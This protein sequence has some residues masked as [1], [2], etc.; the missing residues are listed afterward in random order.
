AGARVLISVD[1]P[2]LVNGRGAS[3]PQPGR[4]HSDRLPPAPTTGSPWARI[5]GGPGA[6]PPP[7]AHRRPVVRPGRGRSDRP[8][9]ADL[10]AA[11]QLGG[12]GCRSHHPR[13]VGAVTEWVRW[14][15]LEGQKGRRVTRAR[16]FLPFLGDVRIGTTLQQPP[17]HPLRYRSVPA[18]ACR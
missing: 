15:L 6:G 16:D 1:S 12:G 9:G 10:G 14:R 2:P 18:T 8:E 4:G 17:A 11:G 13:S 7:R 5:A 3:C